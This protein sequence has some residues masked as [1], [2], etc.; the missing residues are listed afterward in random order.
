MQPKIHISFFPENAGLVSA[1]FYVE[2]EADI[3]GW[4]GTS[5]QRRFCAAFFMAE[6][7]YAKRATVL[8]R[9]LYGDV[10]GPWIA[11]YPPN[12]SRNRC[13]L[14]ETI[15]HELERIQFE[16]I[17]EWLFFKNDPAIDAELAAY[18]GQ[19]L[20]VNALNIKSRRLRRLSRKDGTWTYSTAG[21]DLNVPEFL[22]KHLRCHQCGVPG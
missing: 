4:Y 19:N 21:T 8:H 9:S 10:Y 15:R 3:F 13:P 5:S 1:L 17:S 22:Q 12:R 11:D 14:P 18:Q 6:N 7:F 2:A 20:P 16:F